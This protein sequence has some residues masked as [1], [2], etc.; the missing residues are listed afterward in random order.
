[1]DD[2]RAAAAGP[3]AIGGAWREPPRPADPS[4]ALGPGPPPKP[5]T[6]PGPGPAPGHQPEPSLGAAPL[7]VTPFGGGTSGRRSLTVQAGAGSP[8]PERPALWP[9]VYGG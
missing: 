2:K 9:P 1:M 7:P 4:Q 5:S 6:A 8:P 3:S